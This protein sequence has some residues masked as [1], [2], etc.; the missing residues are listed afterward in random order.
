MPPIPHR[1]QLES[2][3]VEHL[4]ERL[5]RRYA[6]RHDAAAVRATVE[7]VA[8]RYATVGVHAFV[9]VLI[10]RDARRELDGTARTIPRA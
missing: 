2:H 5:I 6:A 10:E 4:T 7:R 9:P 3:A 8:K 1:T